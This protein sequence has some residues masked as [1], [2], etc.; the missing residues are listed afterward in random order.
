MVVYEIKL[1]VYMLKNISVNEIQTKITSLLDKGFLIDTKWQQFHE[2]NFYKGYS[3][4]HAYPLEP[5]KVYKKDKIYIITIRTVDSN[6]A[7]YFSEICVNQFTEDIKGLTAQIRILPKKY[8]ECIYTLT[9][10]IL[11]DAQKGYWKTHMNLEQFELQLKTNLFKK[12]NYFEKTKVVE[13]FPIYNVIEFL[14]QAPIGM[15]YKNVKLLGDKIKLW[16]ADDEMS[17]NLAYM[18]LG[19]GLGNMNS[20]GA[21]YVNY[22][23][24]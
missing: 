15:D 6:L 21:G 2:Q 7:K 4:N 1:K 22:R 11:K 9:P 5:D 12:W 13:N 8:I 14:N 24:M 3:M 17:Q 19:T 20:R 16:I 10:I 18:A 23:W